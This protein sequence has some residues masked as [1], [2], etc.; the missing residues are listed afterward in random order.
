MGVRILRTGPLASSVVGPHA[1]GPSR[2]LAAHAQ[3]GWH[4]DDDFFR[5]FLDS[6]YCALTLV[7]CYTDIPVNG[8]GTWLCED[9]LNGV[10]EY[11]YSNRTGLDPPFP[12]VDT[13]CQG[14]PER[15]EFTQVVA[16]KGDIFV[17]SGRL[18]H[19]VAVNKLHYARVITNPH[20]SLLEPMRFNRPDGNYVRSR[21]ATRTH[22]N[23]QSVVEQQVM[24][25]LGRT[26]IPEFAIER[27]RICWYPPQP[28]GEACAGP[29]GARAH[30]SRCTRQRSP[31]GE[32]RVHL[33][34]EGDPRV[35]SVRAE[36]RVRQGD[37]SGWLE[38]PERGVSGG[39]GGGG[40]S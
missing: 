16:K 20:V 37:L 34:E 1:R 35:G 31:Q 27:E 33:P 11:L 32:R 14:I 7:H 38:G 23:I 40:T 22:A 17:L 15:K 28:R 19:T 3:N 12:F 26:A 25:S 21:R 24:R 39:R 36:E 6:Q 9:G 13:I 18:P 2:P 5:L 29:S 4:C 30:G 10:N 8:G